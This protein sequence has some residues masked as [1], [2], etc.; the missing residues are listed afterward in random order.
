[1]SKLSDRLGR[2]R[3][4]DMK[5]RSADV[6]AA[7]DSPAEGSAAAGRAGRSRLDSVVARSK[8]NRRREE[9]APIPAPKGWAEA[10]PGVYLRERLIDLGSFG[11]SCLVDID[12]KRPLPE[13]RRLED[14]AALRFLDLETT[15]LSGVAGTV[16]FLAGIARPTAEGLLLTQV[17]LADFPFEPG[18]LGLCAHMLDGEPLMVSYNG[19]AFDS[20][21]LEA[22]FRMCGM[23][24]PEYRQLD[25][26]HVARRIYGPMLPDASLKTVEAEILG[27]ERDLDIPGELIPERYFRYLKERDPALLEEVFEHHAQDIAS[28]A[29]LFLELSLIHGGRALLRA[30][31]ERSGKLSPHGFARNL[32]GLGR[33]GDAVEVAVLGSAS[34]EE[35]GAKCL[36][37]LARLHRAAGRQMEEGEARE[38]LWRLTGE[39]EDGRDLCKYLEHRR[40]DFAGAL[41]LCEGLRE[42]EGDDGDLARRAGRLRVK[43]ARFGARA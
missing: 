38:E 13:E 10:A 37:L 24:P 2:I 6:P 17:F 18:L 4:Q 8:R 29:A 19:R 30:E 34:R 27:V 1:M 39:L 15:G 12:G 31:G 16:A 22:R 32:L 42:R 33:I 14:P 41:A 5:L 9:E 40:R 20:K 36:R 26:L 43:V 3:A 28:T 21:L 11:N 35:E 25:L 7:G 23:K